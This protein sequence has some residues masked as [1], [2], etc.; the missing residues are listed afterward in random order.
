MEP[1]LC[2]KSYHFLLQRYV[3]YK[4]YHRDN[5]SSCCMSLT[6]HTCTIEIVSDWPHLLHIWNV[7]LPLTRILYFLLL[8]QVGPTARQQLWLRPFPAALCGALPQRSAYSVQDIKF[9]GSLLCKFDF[10]HVEDSHVL[11]SWSVLG[12]VYRQKF[13]PGTLQV[14]LAA[15]KSIPKLERTPK[16]SLPLFSLRTLV[17][18]ERLDFHPGRRVCRYHPSNPRLMRTIRIP[19]RKTLAVELLLFSDG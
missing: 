8:Q 11:F 6:A 12:R 4:G 9:K 16:V 18:C 5:S 17:P 15:G 2:Y 7:D 13:P 19:P 1:E 10:F 14:P 3:H